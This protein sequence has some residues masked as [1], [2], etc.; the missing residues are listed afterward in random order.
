ML[1]KKE[2][3]V[4]RLRLRGCQYKD[5]PGNPKDAENCFHRVVLKMRNWNSFD[6]EQPPTK[7][8]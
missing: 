5:M 6:Y 2:V 1:T 4:L 7:S 8:P 3:I